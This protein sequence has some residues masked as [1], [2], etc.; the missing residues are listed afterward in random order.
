MRT[1]VLFLCLMAAPAPLPAAPKKAVPLVVSGDTVLVIKS[2]PA[3]VTAP[4][5]ADFY[6]WNVPDSV[7]AT[8]EDNV[9]TVASAPKGSTPVSVVSVTIEFGTD[10]KGKITKKVVKDRGSVTLN[11]GDV[12]QPGPTPGPN[13][14]QP[15]PTPAPIPADGLRVLIVEDV[16]QRVKL[17]AAQSAILF[18]KSVRDYLNSKCVAGADSKTK[19]WRIWDKG[20]DASAESKLWQDAVKRPAKSYPW[21]IISDGKTGYEGPLPADVDATLALLKKYG[22]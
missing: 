8:A 17:P 13:P 2:F 16:A 18:D 1:V 19:E 12:P 22:G 10:D 11:V 9:L 20:V 5:G 14:P 4:A 15:P 6:L 21:L 7:K 3:T